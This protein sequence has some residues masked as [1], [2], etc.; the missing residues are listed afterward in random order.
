MCPAGPQ[1]PKTL[2]CP[3][4]AFHY[5]FS[6]CYPKGQCEMQVACA[7]GQVFLAITTSFLASEGAGSAVLLSDLKVHLSGAG[8]A[9]RE[10][11]LG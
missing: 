1:L 7:A 10:K 5:Q 2:P 6:T 3:R 9:K 11:D 8:K 4:S